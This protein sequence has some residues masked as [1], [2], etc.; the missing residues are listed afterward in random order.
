MKD[1][2]NL[3]INF[4]NPHHR[5]IQLHGVGKEAFE[6]LLV[7]Q[8]LIAV[9]R[10]YSWKRWKLEYLTELREH[11]RQKAVKCYV[12]NVDDGVIIKWKVS[13]DTE[14]IC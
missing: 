14:K 6:K 10:V 8:L 4:A 9:A 7:S 13:V 12:I 11:Q 1:S 3:K 5:Q 2:N